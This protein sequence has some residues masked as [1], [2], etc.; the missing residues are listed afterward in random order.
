MKGRKSMRKYKRYGKRHARKVRKSHRIAKATEVKY[1]YNNT[2][3]IVYSGTTAMDL[4]P[5]SEGITASTRIANKVGIS[6]IQLR[7]NIVTDPTSGAYGPDHGSVSFR[8][9]AVQ[10]AQFYAAAPTL[11][12]VLQTP[13]D[14]ILSPYVL[15]NSKRRRV[16]IL[17][18]KM[19]AIRTGTDSTSHLNI[20]QPGSRLGRITLKNLKYPII[21]FSGENLYGRGQIYLF[22]LSD[23]ADPS[24]NPQSTCAL[25]WVTY[26]RDN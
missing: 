10:M 15:D 16:R 2:N 17:Y 7:Y 21:D 22:V 1:L 19:F 9:I 5:I 11:G 26:Y 4:T 6:S 18:D 14:P 3:F 24:L 20:Y 25:R 8:I 13:A 23:L 12:E